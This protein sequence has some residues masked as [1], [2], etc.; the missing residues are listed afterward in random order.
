MSM[1]ESM[2]GPFARPAAD[3]AGGI[4]QRLLHQRIVVLS[5][6]LDVAAS[7]QVCGALLLLANED[8]RADVTLYVTAS[9]G[10]LSA[11]LAVVDTMRAMSAPVATVAL[12]SVGG[13]GQLVLSAGAKGRRF[14][15]PHSRIELCRLLPGV[16]GPATGLRG[17]AE[18]LA[19]AKRTVYG[20]LAEVTGQRAEQV[21]ADSEA[22]RS[23]E[24]EEAVAYGLV[25]EVITSLDG[26][27]PARRTP[28]GLA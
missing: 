19:D 24:P 20:L 8:P 9:D 17:Q 13:V 15:L 16:L 12:G 5:D 1:S 22:G 18:S 21:A 23:F 25:D 6:P 4:D 10:T 27:V 11:A 7:G 2:I 26:L 28:P 14:T 3:A